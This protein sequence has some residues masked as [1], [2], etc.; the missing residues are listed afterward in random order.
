MKKILLLAFSAFYCMGVFAQSF[1]KKPCDEKIVSG[2]KEATTI[3]FKNETKEELM[4][5]WI[6]FEGNNKFFGKIPA[7]SQIEQATFVEQYWLITD[8]NKNC[9]G[10]YTS[11]KAGRVI[12]PIEK[13][14]SASPYL[15]FNTSAQ[16]SEQLGFSATPPQVIGYYQNSQLYF[17]WKDFESERVKISAYTKN[18]RSFE[19]KWL[20]DVPDGLDILGGFTSDGQSL[21]CMTAIKE[22]MS[23]NKNIL[24]YRNGILNLVKMNGQGDKIW[25]KNLNTPEILKEPVFSPTTAGTADLTFGN[26]NLTLI[27]A[28][29][30]LPDQNGIRHQ[31]SNYLLVNAENGNS[32]KEHNGSISWRHSFDQRVIFDGKDFVILD[33]GDA[34]WYMP[35]GGIALNKISINNNQVEMP[36][37]A[38]GIFIYA[39]QSETAGNQ[40]FSFISMGD[41][42]LGKSGYGVL[43]TS[44][45]TNRNQ[46]RQ[47]WKQPILEPRNVGF[48]HAVKD[49]E[50]VKD[51]YIK[52]QYENRANEGNTY[53]NYTK[54]SIDLI[55]ITANIVDTRKGN[56]SAEAGGA[57]ISRPDKPNL[58]FKQAS[59]AWLTNYP[60]GQNFTSA[61]RP[62][63]IRLSE[64][65]Y[66]AIWEEWTVQAQSNKTPQVSYKSTQA[67]IVD[68]Y[69]NML[70]SVKPVQA[71]LNPSGADKLF[72]LDGK[73][74]WLT[75]ENNQWVLNT[76]DKNLNLEV[77][78]LDF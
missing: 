19:K 8:L 64:N 16:S 63:L 40:N 13:S 18:G 20:K 27:Y 68:E 28:G 75:S 52:S 50:K 43:F 71:R 46:M 11:L 2:G 59:V 45:K 77:I 78:K 10:K 23:E 54:S 3:V 57:T 44:E 37:N 25:T 30:T 9:M 31:T 14:K 55:N 15:L 22:N 66:L 39:R 36:K 17:A 53:V 12:I 26:G 6:D 41:I 56:P 33:L 47:G 58:Q 4:Y 51:G 32:K 65:E 62:K 7:L 74:A 61:E 42:V 69:G 34:G 60:I 24:G 49:F 73:A 21:Y 70:S 35:A 67:V 29:N 76:L 72:L 1:E 38:E 5:Y 48:V